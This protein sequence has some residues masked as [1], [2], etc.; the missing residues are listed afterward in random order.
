MNSNL[1][2]RLSFLCFFFISTLPWRMA[3][4]Q[5]KL[6][7]KDLRDVL[8]NVSWIEQSNDGVII[9]AGDKGLAGVDN[10]SGEI[11]WHNPELKAVN[12][13]SFYLVEGLPVFHVQYQPLAGKTR[14]LLIESSSGKI[15]FDS[16]DEQMEIGK[17]SILPQIS[18]ILFEAKQASQNKLLL[19]DYA[20][21][22]VKWM[23]DQGA[24]PGL[25]KSV[26]NKAKNLTGFLAFPPVVIDNTKL[27]V[28]EDKK[29]SLLDAS[30]GKVLWS[31][32]FK[33][34][35]KA[36]VYSPVGQRIYAGV[37]NRLQ[38]M[39]SATGQDITDSKMKLG[40]ELITVFPNSDNKIVVVDA[41]SFNILDP[42]TNQFIWKKSV[43][44]D[45]LYDV[46]EVDNHYYAVGSEEKSSV[47]AK[48]DKN[49]ERI[50]KAKLDGYA[51]YVQPIAT[52][53]FYLSSEKSNILQYET[54]DKIWKKDIK[55]SAIPAVNVDDKSQEVV[56]FEGEKLHKFS[57]KNG[58]LEALNE[59]IAFKKTKDA[60]FQ[61]E[62]RP[63]GYF[64]FANQHLAF[65]DKGGKLA[66]TSYYEP[67]ATT[68]GLTQIAEM[69]VYATTGVDLDIQGSLE[70]IAALKSLS[71][72]AYRSGGDQSEGSSQSTLIA[73]LYANNVPVFE[74][75]K[76][77][78]F[79]SREA[80]DHFYVLS[81]SETEGNQILRIQKEPGKADKKISLTDK[82]PSY[83]VDEVD[84]VV[85]VSEKN[86]LLTAYKMK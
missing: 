62:I 43:E 47:I 22:E 25:V 77:R 30:Q 32:E 73:G 50:W 70:S 31:Q 69:G 44:V 65:V 37:K 64:I 54:G 20:K 36:V 51:Y 11:R 66:Y 53:V 72:G 81:K 52:G 14:S 17:Y 26:V 84:D 21:G 12:R 10:Y 59:S 9:A 80:K 27:L 4:S 19:F 33:D 60:V 46:I 75:S 79:N 61:L 28:A 63:S 68:E 18:G 58:N 55:F 1:I 7:E 35:L 71:Q 34:K 16:K 13:N 78:Y 76:K 85:F 5:E 38:I 40:G 67:V 49:S 2:S 3:F 45:G 56:F 57:L 29:V 83:V 74:V 48:V 15:L 82:T 6:W 23:S 39:E 41:A 24:S 8:Y 86:H 42:A